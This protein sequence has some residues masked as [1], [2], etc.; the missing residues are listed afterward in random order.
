MVT[1]LNSTKEINLQEENQRLVTELRTETEARKAISWGLFLLTDRLEKL[2][3]FSTTAA[4]SF[5][6]QITNLVDCID[7]EFH[8]LRQG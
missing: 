7:C 6:T 3:G 2:Q 8:L 1:N 4:K 5:K